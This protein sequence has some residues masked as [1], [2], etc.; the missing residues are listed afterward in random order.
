MDVKFVYNS[1]PNFVSLKLVLSQIKIFQKKKLITVKH[2][3]FT[4]SYFRGLGSKK[5]RGI[6]ISRLELCHYKIL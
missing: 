1:K 3:I 4:A 2:F 5:F 6:L